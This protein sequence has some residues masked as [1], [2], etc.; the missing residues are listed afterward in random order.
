[1]IEIVYGYGMASERDSIA[2]H[3]R[4]LAEAVTRQGT[5][6]CRVS[7]VDGQAE[8]RA[9]RS[10]LI[11]YNPYSYGARLGISP[12]LVWDINRL[13]RRSEVDRLMVFVH[14]PWIP[15]VDAKSAAIGTAQRAQLA[16]ICAQADVVLAATEVYRDQLV[17]H[18]QRSRP[19]LHLPVG[20]NV[21]DCRSGRTAL[22]AELGIPDQAVVFS[23]IG[24]DHP[25]RLPG[26]TRSVLDSVAALPVPTVLIN[27]GPDALPVPPGV[28]AITPGWVDDA[29]FATLLGASDIFLAPLI[30]GV[31][32]RRT[33]LI[34][35]LQHGVP[36]VGTRTSS[37]DD[38]LLSA[39][40][41]MDLVQADDATGFADASARLALDPERRERMGEAARALFDREFAWP[42]LAKRFLG[43]MER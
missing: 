8:S 20:S 30:D 3:G 38:V 7:S 31:S 41:A 12:R 32:T 18:I 16:L 14:E 23:H 10:V 15:I 17:R 40:D 21:P 9:A 39:S 5:T 13:G 4:L 42:V 2:T 6:P 37:S 36:V 43:L 26:H 1:M 34:A 27:L 33:S 11:Q 19:V 28:R 29:R 22:R 25:S 35:A 24:S